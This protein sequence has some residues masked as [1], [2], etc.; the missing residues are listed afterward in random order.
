MVKDLVERAQA[1]LHTFG[2]VGSQ[3]SSDL[4]VEVIKL[5]DVI[6]SI[7][8]YDS[9]LDADERAPTGDDYNELISIVGKERTNAQG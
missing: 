1:E 5:R 3:T 9:K 8:S 4:L 6:Q 2:R 7:R